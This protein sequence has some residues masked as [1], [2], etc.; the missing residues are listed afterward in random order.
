MSAA[1]DNGFNHHVMP[2]FQTRTEA[3]PA[4][5]VKRRS[6]SLKIM[7]TLSTENGQRGYYKSLA[8]SAGAAYTAGTD[9]VC[10]VPGWNA[11]DV[12]GAYNSSLL[13]KACTIS[14]KLTIYPFAGS[15]L[16]KRK[17]ANQM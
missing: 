10:E 6:E 13:S 14:P 12:V 11:T 9:T 16:K 17:V 2:H 4:N 1:T 5:G 3:D 15:R 7:L 8:E